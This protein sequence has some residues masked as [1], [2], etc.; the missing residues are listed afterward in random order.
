MR[1]GRTHSALGEPEAVLGNDGAGEGERE[2]R[3]GNLHGGCL[4][5]SQ[6]VD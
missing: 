3:N 4:L 2:E 5:G 1:L 6:K